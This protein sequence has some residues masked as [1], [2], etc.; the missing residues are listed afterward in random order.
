MEDKKLYW[1]KPKST[2]SIGGKPQDV[3]KPIDQ[4]IVS[5]DFIERNIKLGFIGEKIGVTEIISES[6]SKEIESLRSE[7]EKTSKTIG[8]LKGNLSKAN[9]KI[10][11]LEAAAKKDDK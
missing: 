11:E 10:K 1:I 6:A 2:Y 5:K 9:A 7:K 3:S 4:K 8:T